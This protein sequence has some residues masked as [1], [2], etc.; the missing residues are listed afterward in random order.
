MDMLVAARA[1]WVSLTVWPIA[2]VRY[3]LMSSRIAWFC[4]VSG[5]RSRLAMAMAT[6]ALGVLKTCL[7]PTLS[8]ALARSR[9]QG[10][11]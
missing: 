4:G 11:L 8:K 1:H 2:T 6:L 7:S 3:A 10:P 9:G 5:I